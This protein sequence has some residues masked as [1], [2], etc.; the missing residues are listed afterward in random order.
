MIR[1]YVR[2]TGEGFEVRGDGHRRSVTVRSRYAATGA[3]RN[4]AARLGH[5]SFTLVTLNA[6]AKVVRSAELSANPTAVA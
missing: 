2:P 3:A 4:L 6:A 1:V 5:D